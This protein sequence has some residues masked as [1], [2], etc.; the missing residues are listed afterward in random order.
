M[1]I[2]AP[3]E[4]RA[5]ARL[6][7]LLRQLREASD[8]LRIEAAFPNA[9]TTTVAKLGD[10]REDP[11]GLYYAAD[12]KRE[13]RAFVVTQTK[14]MGQKRGRSE[15]S[16]VRETAVQAVEFYRDIVQ[17]L[18]AWQAPAPK[19][20]VDPETAP[21]DTTSGPISPPWSTEQTPDGGAGRDRV[22]RDQAP[23]RCPRARAAGR[24]LQVARLGLSG[25]SDQR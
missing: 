25:S 24:R 22:N 17:N 23:G 1:A 5:K 9:R 21:A 11:A 13:P 2:D 3:R 18:K 12:P 4:G 14:S 7:W 10:I 16:F 6:N 15:G 19:L 20:R 8:E